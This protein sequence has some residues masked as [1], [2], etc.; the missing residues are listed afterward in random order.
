MERLVLDKLEPCPYL[1]ER[2]A[3]MPLRWQTRRLTGEEADLSFARG[4]RRV[5]PM[6]YRTACPE[7]SACTPIRIPTARLEHSRSLRKVWK[8]NQDLQIQCGPAAFSGE[9]LELFNRHRLER[10]LSTEP[11]DPQSYRAWFLTTCLETTEIR[12]LDGGRLVG[13]SILD[14]GA[15]AASS[16]YHC[17]DPTQ[18]ERSL[19]TFSVLAEAAWCQERG[20]DWYYLGLYVAECRHLVYKARFKPHERLIGGT[21]LPDASE[22]PSP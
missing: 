1:P 11:L 2:M 12:Y 4:E 20:L 14:I 5:G 17:F 10:S 18:S 13:L 7:C 3:R 21:W 19:G 16:V 8:R 22:T 6:L 9:R 15:T